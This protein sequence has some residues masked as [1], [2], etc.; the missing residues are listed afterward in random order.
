MNAPKESK[1]LVQTAMLERVFALQRAAFAH[2]R[3]PSLAVR[4][5]RVERVLEIVAQKFNLS[6]DKL[7]GRDRS[8]EI[9][10]PRQ[11]AM[12]IL[13]EVTNFSLPQI[14]ELLGGRDHTTVM[15]AIEKI[16]EIKTDSG[17]KVIRDIMDI[18]R[19]L[20]AGLA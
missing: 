16:E 12:Y 15:Y 7:L 1:V 18:Q 20:Q 10:L 11:I 4:K 13:R 9:A 6:V 5:S 2:E 8:R 3:F 19:Q 14:G 17:S